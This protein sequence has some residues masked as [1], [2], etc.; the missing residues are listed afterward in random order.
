[1][2]YRFINQ[3][4]PLFPIHFL[5]QVMQVSRSAYYGYKT[6]R[7]HQPISRHQQALQAVEKVFWDH[8]QRYGSRLKVELEEMQG[9]CLGRHRIRRLMKQQDLVAIQRLVLS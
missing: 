7:S 1:M 9:L 8:K 2:K 5:C 6:G 3:C 4:E